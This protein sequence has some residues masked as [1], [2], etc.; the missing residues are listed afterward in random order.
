M[1]TFLTFLLS[2]W[3]V[4]AAEPAV[5]WNSETIRCGNL[6][7]GDS[8]TSVCFADAFLK[9]AATRT[10][11]NISSGLS[12]IA[13]GSDQVFTTPFCIFTGEGNFVLKDSE[14][15]NLKKYLENGGFI[16]ASPGCSNA[17]WNTAFRREIALSITGV[18]MKTIPMDHDLFSTVHKISSLH[19]K[20]SGTATL[21]GIFVN[22]RL[23]MVYSPE[24][25]N[26]VKNAKGC[27]C[28]GGNEIKEAG[29]VNVNAVAY[30]L[31]H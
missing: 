28:C 15:A 31:L 9:E 17:E 7:Y 12:K 10:G 4:H 6:S 25:L 21:Q 29:Q 18:Q 20:N 11:L 19:L 2:A 26:D 3:F 14:R 23:A 1:K 22:G 30:A 13:L 27:C 16:L 8:Q 24:G 5:D